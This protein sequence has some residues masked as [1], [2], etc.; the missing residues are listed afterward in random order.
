MDMLYPAEPF[1]R[2]YL[3]GRR[4]RVGMLKGRGLH[5]NKAREHGGISVEQSASAVSTETAH[6]GPGRVNR[7]R[8]ALRQG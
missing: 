3:H 1:G 4:E 2:L 5:V 7:L 6:R 8:L